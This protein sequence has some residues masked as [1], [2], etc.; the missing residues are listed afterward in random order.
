M[1]YHTVAGFVLAKL[2]RVPLVP[3]IFFTW[4]DLRIEIIDMD[5]ARIDKVVD[6][7]SQPVGRQGLAA[8]HRPGR[9][10]IGLVTA[11]ACGPLTAGDAGRRPAAT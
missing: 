8:V 5:G 2:G 3:G 1:E 4:R 6:R 10:T 9:L 7:A 11:S